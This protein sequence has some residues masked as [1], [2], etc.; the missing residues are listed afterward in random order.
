M[1]LCTSIEK[2]PNH[3]KGN[4]QLCFANV[5]IQNGFLIKIRILG[6]LFAELKTNKFVGQ[7]V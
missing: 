4:A 5:L 2:L 6:L 7:F 1:D 3:P